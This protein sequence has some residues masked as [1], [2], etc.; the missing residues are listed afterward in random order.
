VRDPASQSISSAYAVAPHLGPAGPQLITAANSAFVT[1]MHWA[2]GVGAVIA[3]GGVA[4]VLAWLPQYSAAQNPPEPV[5][6]SEPSGTP[7]PLD[8]RS[9]LINEPSPRK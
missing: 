4:V 6:E 3:L 5:P 7:R 8:F 9:T 1:A 2:A